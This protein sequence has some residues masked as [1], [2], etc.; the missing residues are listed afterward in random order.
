MARNMPPLHPHRVLWAGDAAPGSPCE[1]SG[2]PQRRESARSVPGGRRRARNALWRALFAE[3]PL[4]YVVDYTLDW[5]AWAVPARE[6]MCMNAVR[7]ISRRGVRV[8]VLLAFALLA[9]NAALALQSFTCI[10]DNLAADCAIGESQ[11]SAELT[12]NVLTITMT[13][14][15]AGVVQQIFIEGAGITGISFVSSVALGT[16]AFG[17]G[18]AGGNLPG[19]NQPGVSFTEIWNIAANNPSPRNGIG[20]HNQ[21]QNSTQAGEFILSGDLTDLRVGVHVIGFESGGSESFVTAPIPEPD[22]L[23]TFC[24]GALIVGYQ[25]RRRS[26]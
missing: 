1:G 6:R 9:S 18:A 25:G 13:G 15:D 26:R 2:R 7:K 23:L 24:V 17:T 4:D 20:W 14:T 12:G 5:N 21:D 22:A 16:V 19:G 3:C 10:T 11:L 8:I